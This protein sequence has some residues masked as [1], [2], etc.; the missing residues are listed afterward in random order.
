MSIG[1]TS[2]K[3]QILFSD[4]QKRPV[5]IYRLLTAGAIDGNFFLYERRTFS[6]RPWFVE[7]I[8]QRQMTKL[9]LSDCEHSE[10]Y[11]LFH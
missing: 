5:F 1:S 4:G 11:N 2:L 9:A 6:D 7:K 8:Y 10:F 3:Y